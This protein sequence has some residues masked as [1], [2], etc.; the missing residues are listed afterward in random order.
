MAV[1]TKT[2]FYVTFVLVISIDFVVC[3]ASAEQLAKMICTV[4][5]SVALPEHFCL[6]YGFLVLHS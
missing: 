5:I 4:M 6:N 3:K 2:L 1:K